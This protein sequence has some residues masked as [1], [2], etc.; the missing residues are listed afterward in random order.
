MALPYRH[1]K[2]V[3]QN[4]S[5]GSRLVSGTALLYPGNIFSKSVPSG[6]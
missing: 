3:V 1:L 6:T 2:Y 5:L 4:K